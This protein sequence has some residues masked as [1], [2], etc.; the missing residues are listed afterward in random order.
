[1][2][3]LLNIQEASA[4]CSVRVETMRNWERKGKITPLRTPGG[5]R[6]YTE[7]MLNEVLN[8]PNIDAE[9]EIACER[10]K[11]Y[12]QLFKDAT[13]ALNQRDTMLAALK[14]VYRY[15]QGSSSVQGKIC[16]DAIA[17]I[18]SPTQDQ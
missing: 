12:E 5:H 7:Q 14:E 17:S 3:K 18:E 8:Q 9:Y 10:L 1:M 2:E 11:S 16:R 15:H 4:R 6:R 13:E